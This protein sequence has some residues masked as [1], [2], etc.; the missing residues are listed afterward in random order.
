M[1]SNTSQAFEASL[2]FILR[3]EGGFVDD[4]DDRGGAPTRA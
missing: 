2:P 3:W 4:P 1:Q